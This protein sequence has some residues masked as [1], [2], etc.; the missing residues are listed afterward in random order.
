M[1]DKNP[2]HPP[3][4]AIRFLEWGLPDDTAEDIMGDLYELY[5]EKIQA[6]K[7]RKATFDYIFGTFSLIQLF[8]P[9]ILPDYIFPTHMIKHYITVAFRNIRKH[10]GYSLIN[11]FG[12]ATGLAACLLIL[13][14]VNHELSYDSFHEKADQIYRVSMEFRSA[15]IQEHVA[16]SPTAALPVFTREYPEVIGGVRLYPTGMFRPSV[17]EYG[18]KQFQ[19]DGFMY[20]DSTFFNVFSFPL[21]KGNPQ[22]CLSQPTTIVITESMAMKYFGSEDP[23][24]KFLKINDSREYQV[25]GVMADFPSNSHFSADFLASFVSTRAAKQEIWGSA[26]YQTYIILKKGASAEDLEAKIP[27]LIQREIGQHLGEDESLIIHLTAL[28]DVHLRSD[29]QGGFGTSGNI[30]YVYIF[31][32]IALLI[33]VIACINYMNLAT[34][35]SVDRAK[36]VGLRKVVG[37]QKNQLFGQFMGEATIITFMALVISLVIANLALPYFNQLVGRE[38][39]IG[40]L[41]NA[42]LIFGLIGVG[43][44]VSLLAGVYPAIAFSNFKPITILRGNF[45]TSQSGVWLRKGLVIFQFAISIFLVV[46]TLVIYKQLRLIQNKNLG[47]EK[48]QVVVIPVDYKMVEKWET[49]KG[50]LT[51]SPHIDHVSAV[52]ETPSQVDGTYSLFLPSNPKDS[53]LVQ[54]MATDIDIAKTMGFKILSGSDYTYA[55]SQREDYPFLINETVM[56]QMGWDLETAVGKPLNLNGR[57]GFVQAVMNDFHTQSLHREVSPLVIFLSKND[58]NYAMVKISTGK[59]EESLSHLESTWSELAPHR[60]FDYHFL[61]DEFDKLYRSEK[62]TAQSLGIFAGLAIIIASLGLFGLA[63]FTTVQRSKEIGIR[64]VLGAS[65]YQL[66]GLLS[67]DFTQ[68]VLV[69][70]VIALPLAWYAMDTWLKDFATRVNV[71]ADTLLIAGGAALVI[72]WLTVSYQSVRTAMMNPIDTLKDE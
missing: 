17:I 50:A 59:I 49:F 70:A 3:K 29:A 62:Q 37:A 52:S 5:L 47:Y 8:R 21:L 15:D 25:T 71:G 44:I 33:L 48:E 6:G 32:A 61:D 31:S 30:R 16:I 45:K 13:M 67:K 46:G 69:S 63:A 1:A 20:A 10:T 19:E 36:E 53:R 18:E 43:I 66:V 35:R 9:Q 64:K 56:K 51:N 65:S 72:S 34:A 12:L 57:E 42:T 38:L 55:S 26:N 39:S 22:T 14:Y 23:M 41:N 2:H 60:P 28:E 27:T 24:G 68:L 58:F 54:A 11:I 7:K 4:W 40:F